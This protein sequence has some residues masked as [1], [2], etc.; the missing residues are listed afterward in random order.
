[1]T[2]IALEPTLLK[3]RTGGTTQPCKQTGLLKEV[4]PGGAQR[5]CGDH[6][7][8]TQ[9]GFHGILKSCLIFHVNVDM[10]WICPMWPKCACGDQKGP[11]GKKTC[12]LAIH[13][14]MGQTFVDLSKK[15]Y[16]V[17]I[18]YFYGSKSGALG[19]KMVFRD[20]LD[21]VCGSRPETKTGNNHKGP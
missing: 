15:Q 4:C 16:R 18:F 9:L 6:L 3:L 1:M 7:H 20:V 8:P 17:F 14:S 19:Q 12:R 21:R 13:L 10:R 2:H 5:S 11:F